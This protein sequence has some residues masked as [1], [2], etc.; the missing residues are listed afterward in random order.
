MVPDPKVK[1]KLGLVQVY[2]GNGKG[3]TTACLG[4]AFRAAG[5]GLDVLMLQFLKP[6]KGYGEHMA[7]EMI[8]NF[9]IVPMGADHM[10][11]RDV[12]R[13]EDMELTRLGMEKAEEALVSGRYDLVI[14]DEI[15]NTMS[16]GLAT[17]QDVIAMLERRAP[18]TEVVL[19]GRGVPKEIIEYADLVTEMVLVKH[20]FDKGIGARKGIEY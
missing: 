5:R 16:F 18:N 1:K 14:L 12:T 17:P 7:A 10:C 2:T 15:N 9:T 19:S 8:P 13:E 4:L 6:D 11:G 3:K 20:P